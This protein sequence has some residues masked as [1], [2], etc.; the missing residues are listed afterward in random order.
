[1]KKDL[2]LEELVPEGIYLC[3]LDHSVS[4]S[5]DTNEWYKD[6]WSGFTDSIVRFDGKRAHKFRGV[7]KESSISYEFMGFSMISVPNPTISLYNGSQ[8]ILPIKIDLFLFDE[9]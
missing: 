1:M 7:N 3:R 9:L 5:E 4:I 6:H 8:G 2:K